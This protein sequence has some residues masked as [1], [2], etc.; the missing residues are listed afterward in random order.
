MSDESV[1]FLSLATRSS[2]SEIFHLVW[3]SWTLIGFG[4]NKNKDRDVTASVVIARD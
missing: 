2:C 4:R 1:E 3:E